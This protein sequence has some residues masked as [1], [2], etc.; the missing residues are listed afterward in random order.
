MP[1]VFAGGDVARGPDDVIRAIAD[2]KRAAM[3]MDKYLGG[4]GIL[5][6]GEPIEIPEI[7]DSDEIVF[8]TQFEKEVLVPERRV[9]SFEEVVKGYH[10]INAIAEAMRCL[11]CDRRA[12]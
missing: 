6:K 2:G 9:K 1:G 4:K 12:L 3:A 11:H 10:K 5:N 8:H 7:M